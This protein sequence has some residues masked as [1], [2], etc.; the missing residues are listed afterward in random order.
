MDIL[1]QTHDAGALC[2]NDANV[3]TL[4]MHRLGVPRN[5]IKSMFA[6]LQGAAHKIQMAYGISDKTYGLQRE[7]PLQGI[8]QGNGCG[9]AGWAV[10]SNPL[11]NMMW[12]VGFS[13]SL[14]TAIAV[15]AVEF[16]YY[17]FI[18]DTNLMHTAKDAHTRGQTI[19]A[20]MQQAL[21]QLEG[22][23]KATKVVL[24]SQTRATGT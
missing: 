7:L 8:G 9:P 5:P 23:L 16:V 17:T 14:L 15:L 12:M 4:C 21:N 20:E 13:F 2:T 10:I 19:M 18:D 1:W 22:G 24:S 6:T 11:I 3:A